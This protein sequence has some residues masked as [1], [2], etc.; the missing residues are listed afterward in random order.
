MKLFIAIQKMM[1]I[2]MLS[3]YKDYWSTDPVLWDSFINS[4]ISHR[5]Y[6]QLVRY[7]HVTDP[8]VRDAK[9]GKLLKVIH[10]LMTLKNNF[11]HLFTPGRALSIEKAMVKFWCLCDAFTVYC[12]GFE[13]YTGKDEMIKKSLA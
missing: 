6:E 2:K 3:E 5:Q 10:F 13:V 1:G 8:N 9:P 12:L 4:R 11:S 7:L